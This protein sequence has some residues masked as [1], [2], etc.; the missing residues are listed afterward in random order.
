LVVDVYG[1]GIRPDT[2]ETCEAE[3]IMAANT[4]SDTP[5]TAKAD[6]VDFL[7]NLLSAGWMEVGDVT[8]EAISAGLHSEAKQLKDNKPMREARA[9][10]KVET[11]RDGFGKDARYFWALPGTPWAP[12]DPIGA[13]MDP[14]GAHEAP[15]ETSQQPRFRSRRG[16]SWPG[17][18]I[19]MCGR[20][21]HPIWTNGCAQ[22]K[23]R[24]EDNHMRSREMLN[25]L[26][27]LSTPVENDRG[28]CPDISL[29]SPEQQDRVHELFAKIGR[30]DDGDWD[31][32]ITPA[33][34]HE[35]RNLLDGLPLCDKDQG[36]AGPNLEIPWTLCY[37]FTLL[38][39]REQNRQAWPSDNFH[40]LKAVQKV[41][42]VELCRRYGWDGGAPHGIVSFSQ[43]QPEDEAE[44]R[45]LLDDAAKPSKYFG[46]RVKSTA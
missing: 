33:E 2:P 18:S 43:W 21:K 40:D 3:M 6:C 39:W 10:L 42:F 9:A 35:L 38:K 27:K 29:L 44:I 5:R 30:T 45:S 23:T 1:K 34:I 36:F 8:A 26:D 37:H 22:S 24:S 12:S 13:P 16:L 15:E 11:K 46:G 31:C 4:A 28:N 14:K 20:W 19:P 32:T 17:W 41:R 25:K 7:Q